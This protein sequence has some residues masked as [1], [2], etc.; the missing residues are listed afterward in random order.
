VDSSSNLTVW[1][2]LASNLVATGTH[3]MFTTDISDNQRFFRV[4]RVP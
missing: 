4:Y 1:A 3:Y 2:V